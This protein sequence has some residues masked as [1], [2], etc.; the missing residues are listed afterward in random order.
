[1]PCSQNDLRTPSETFAP[2]TVIA[3]EGHAEVLPELRAVADDAGTQPVEYRNRQAARIS[4]RLH[5]QR[6]HR[7]DQNGLCHPLG[8]VAGDVASNLAAAGGMTD[9]DGVLE[10]ELLDQFGKVIGVGVHVVAGPRLARASVA[11]AVMGDASIAARGEVEHLIL[12][13][14]RGKRP[15][16]A[17]DNGLSGAPILVIDLGAVFGRDCAHV[18]L[19][20][21]G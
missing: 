9:M 21:W 17:E 2:G 14:I 7:C 1:M 6:R 8:A 12:E 18:G 19:D 11:A 10:V 16:M 3:V 20:C 4:R 13:C 15:A 5:H